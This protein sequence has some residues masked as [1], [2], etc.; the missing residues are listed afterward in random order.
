MTYFTPLFVLG[1]Y[2]F[3]PNPCVTD[4]CQMA[5]V[6]ILTDS[7]TITRILIHTKESW[8]TVLLT[9]QIPRHFTIDQ[10]LDQ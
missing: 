9:P 1:L 5:M 4:S 6:I 10:F 3:E 8:C 2:F 7:Q